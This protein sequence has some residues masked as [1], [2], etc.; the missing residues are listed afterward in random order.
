MK[1]PSFSQRRH[2]GA[3]WPLVVAVI[4]DVVMVILGL[5]FGF[6][7]RFS[8]GWMPSRE[9]WW[10]TGAAGDGLGLS[11]YL[12]LMG[13]GALLLVGTYGWIGMYEAGNLLRWRRVAM[14]VTRGTAIWLLLYLALSLVMKFSPSI[15]RICTRLRG[16]G[17]R[18][19]PG[20]AGPGCALV[21]E[22][23]HRKGASSEGLFPGLG[24]CGRWVGRVHRARRET[25]V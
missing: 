22:G 9:T 18:R 13:F 15:S 14:V 5:L 19:G 10:T 11:S 12:P 6:W 2:P 20:L 3:K 7:L 17:C 23:V 1:V 25:S 8:S 21:W 24:A 4:G 16:R